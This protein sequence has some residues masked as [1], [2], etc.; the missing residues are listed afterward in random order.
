GSEDDVLARYAGAAEAAA[1]DV[2]VRLT[3]DCPFADPEVIDDLV[4]WRDREGLDY[5]TNVLPPTW[6]DGLDCS[7]FTRATLEAAAANAQLPSEREHVVPWMWVNS[8]VQG[9]GR[10]R[11][12][13]RA[14]PE[15]LS[16]YR[17]T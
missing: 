7:V 12:G 1:A 4:A 5:V 16:S 6:P 3:G 13:N 17:W 11:A 14:A 9:G 10:L 15:N 2:I 8:D